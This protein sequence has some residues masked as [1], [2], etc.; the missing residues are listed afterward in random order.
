MMN[1]SLGMVEL[2]SISRGIAVSDA[3]VKASKIEIATA[4]STCP[5]KYI[6]IISGDVA[7]VENSI[8]VGVRMAGEFI[9]DHFVLPKVHHSV[10]PAITAT[11]DIP[12]TGALGIIEGFSAASIIIAADTALKAARVDAVELRIGS[13]L[14]G[15]AYF[16]L[17]GDL[18]SVTKA[19]EAGK[20][21]VLEKGLLINAEVISA[22]A[23]A[24]WATLL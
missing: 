18:G 6:A 3:M 5:G 14:G 20:Q 22:P 19:V 15:K 21:G 4:V 24:L 12:Q 7:A 11:C 23:K 9:I 10:F 16:M 1:P 2:N 17:C 13:G 8:A